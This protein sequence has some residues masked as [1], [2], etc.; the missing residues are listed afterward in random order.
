MANIGN[1]T[2]ELVD[3]R[4]YAELESIYQRKPQINQTY[5]RG[6]TPKQNH[7]SSRQAN[8]LHTKSTLIFASTFEMNAQVEYVDA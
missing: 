3:E 6:Q 4:V 8:Q 7:A 1:H 5:S 2:E